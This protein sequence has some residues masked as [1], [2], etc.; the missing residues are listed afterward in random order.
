MIGAAEIAAI[1]RG[2]RPA[3]KPDASKTGPSGADIGV[4]TAFLAIFVTIGGWILGSALSPKSKGRLPL[5]LMAF[6]FGGI[7]LMMAAILSMRSFDVL[8]LL[9]L[10]MTA[11]GFRFPLKLQPG[12]GGRGGFGGGGGWSSGGS[13]SGSSSSGGDFGGGSS[14]GGGASDSW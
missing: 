4:I 10:A 5:F 1:L 3:P 2:R 11:V 14:G 7:A 9:G 8:S 6:M 12:N 13:D